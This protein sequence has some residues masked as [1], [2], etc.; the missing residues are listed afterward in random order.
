MQQL[1][2]EKNARSF[3]VEFEIFNPN[4]AVWLC[5]GNGFSNPE[6]LKF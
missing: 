5:I 2:M 3:E 6:T 1:F 4:T